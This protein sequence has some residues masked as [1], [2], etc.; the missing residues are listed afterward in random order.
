[1]YILLMLS[2]LRFLL[3]LYMSMIKTLLVDDDR[4][5]LSRLENKLAPFPSIHV[6]SALSSLGDA[7]SYLSSNEVDLVFLDIQLNDES[8]LNLLDSFSPTD[9]K[10]ICVTG[11]QKYAIDAF[12]KGAVDY[13]VK[14]IQDDELKAAVEKVTIPNFSPLPSEAPKI[15]LSKRTNGAEQSI[16]V[17]TKKGFEIYKIEEIVRLRASGNYTILF[18]ANGEKVLSAKTL[19]FYEEKLDTFN[20]LRINRQDLINFSFITRM[21]KGRYPILE[22]TNGEQLRVSDRKRKVLRQVFAV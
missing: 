22:L 19:K 10:V 13:L 20:F 11:Y 3:K 6:V 14:P 9:L 12:R 2:N 7:A 4:K 16:S 18:T 8:G 15:Q 5:S 1:M 21:H 17:L